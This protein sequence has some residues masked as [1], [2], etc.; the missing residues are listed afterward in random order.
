[1]KLEAA[2]PVSY[3][4]DG[5]AYRIYEEDPQ[6][7]IQMRVKNHYYNMHRLQT[8]DFVRE[9]HKKWL[10]FNHANMPILE[11]L[12]FLSNFLDESDPDVDTPNVCHAYQTAE[13][14]RAA[15]PDKPWMHL[16]GLVHD[17]G[18]VMSVWGEEQWAVTGDTYPVGCSPDP[19]IVYGLKSFE[20]NL[21]INDEKYN[22]SLGMYQPNCGIE[23]L[24][25]TWS[26]DEYM[27]QVLV[28]HGS[29]LPEE[30]LYAIRF[31]SFYPYHS[32][33]AYR[34]FAT[35]RDEKLMPAIMMLNDCDLY[36]KNDTQPDIEAL[37]PYYQSL[38]DKYVPGPVAW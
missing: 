12:D 11:C 29:T 15:H 18:K 33:N 14:L 20:G 36:S 24:L 26:H 6:N 35:E 37:K 30:A 2:S 22:T 32:H 13:R 19:S 7:K 8:V 10:T 27:Y 38:I 34:Q 28:N 5:K 3:E 21:D 16:A 9:M 4:K 17:L 23:N 25:M 31:H 1:M